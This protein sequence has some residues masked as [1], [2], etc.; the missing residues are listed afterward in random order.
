VQV[1]EAP[2]G[3]IDLFSKR[4]TRWCELAGFLLVMGGGET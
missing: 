2:E 3:E 1:K 4:I